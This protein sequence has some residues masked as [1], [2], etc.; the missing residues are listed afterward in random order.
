MARP[1]K[2][3]D[4]T[5][6]R[7]SGGQASYVLE[8]LL[9]ERRVSQSD[10]NGY[11]AQMKQ[12]IGQLE[13]RLKHLRDAVGDAASAAVSGIA[14]VASSAV[15]AVRGRKP[16]RPAGSKNKVGRPPGRPAGTPGRKPGRP[17]K[18][19]AAPAAA[20]TETAAPS[21]KGGKRARKAAITAEQ[22]ASRQFRVAISR[23][24]A[25]SRPTAGR[26][27]PRWPRKRAAR[28]PSKRCRTTC[29]RN[30]LRSRFRK[31]AHASAPFFIT[32][33]SV[34]AGTRP[35]PGSAPATASF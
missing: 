18:A 28:Q 20:A 24:C 4:S 3:G 14:S 31:R 30:D 9:K 7:L 6:S 33:S 5:P 15:A 27:L 26:R 35:R 11:V 22:L 13:E 32:S 23:W 17:P 25:V 2:Q 16:G 12:E 34:C 29:R 8:R 10:V 21:K 19:A 1:R